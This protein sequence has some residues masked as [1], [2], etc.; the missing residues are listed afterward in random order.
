MKITFYTIGYGN[1][2]PAEFVSALQAHGVSTVVDVRFR[3]GR[4]RLNC[5]AKA[6][7]P[8]K[9]IEKLLTAVGIKYESF[10]ELGNPFLDV[11]AW[12]EPYRRRLE[13]D[14]PKLTERLVRLVGSGEIAQPFCLLCAEKQPQDCHRTILADWLVKSLRWEVTPIV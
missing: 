13:T 8:D 1:R 2:T 7:T 11:E 14:G 10:V 9:R 5:Y 6:K 4:A 3:P 12:A